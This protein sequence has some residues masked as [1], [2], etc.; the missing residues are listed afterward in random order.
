MRPYWF[1]RPTI[2]P[3][4]SLPR[5]SQGAPSSNP[6]RRIPL[7]KKKQFLEIHLLISQ[8]LETEQRAFAHYLS[9]PCRCNDD[10]CPRAA[11]E[12][13]IEHGCYGG[14]FT[15]T[16]S[17]LP[18]GLPWASL[19]QQCDSLLTVMQPSFWLSP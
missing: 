10:L 14:L 17:F 9:H 5:P 19:C 4:G 11:W 18:K 6:P 7:K 13:E 15:S 12:T 16:F 8:T 1:V 3:H 2:L